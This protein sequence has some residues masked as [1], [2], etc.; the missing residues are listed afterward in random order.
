M[1]YYIIIQVHQRY[2]LS[3]SSQEY[4]ADITTALHL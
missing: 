2:W 1:V 3:W 4:Y